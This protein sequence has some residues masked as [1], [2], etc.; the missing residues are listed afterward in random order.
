M[1][2]LRQFELLVERLFHAGEFRGPCFSGIGQ[3]AIAA[4]VMSHF[5]DQDWAAGSHRNLNLTL[6]VGLPPVPMLA[7]LL[8]KRTRPQTL[9]VARRFLGIHSV[10]GTAL[11]TA[12]GAA[13]SIKNKFCGSASA[14]PGVAISFCGEGALA[15]GISHETL[16]VAR[17]WSLPMLFVVENNGYAGA[18][19]LKETL[20]STVLDRARSF[21]I[22][23]ASVD[24]NDVRAVQRVSGDLLK[25]V[26]NE[27]TP[28][29]LEA[30][31]YRQRAHTLDDARVYRSREEESRWLQRDPI[32]VLSQ[33]MESEGT[34]PPGRLLQ[35]VRECDTR[36]S[37]WLEE[38]RALPERA[39]TSR[40]PQI[41][42]AS[43]PTFKQHRETIYTQAVYE[44]VAEAMNRD[45]RAVVVGT[46]LGSGGEPLEVEHLRQRFGRD[47]VIN[48]PT[49]PNALC[50]M[51]LGASITGARPIL[52]FPR[53]A[54][55][56]LCAGA[57]INAAQ[58]G[59]ASDEN[60][61]V[62]LVIR[63][64]YG[65]TSDQVRERPQSV[66]R[67]FSHMPGLTI[68]VPATPFDA[69]AMVLSAVDAGE[70]VLLLEPAALQDLRGPVPV[71]I[72][73]ENMSLTG[74]RIAASGDRLTCISY[75]R[76]LHATLAARQSLPHPDNVEVIDLRC[77]QPLD[78]A[79]IVASAAKTGALLIV[80]DESSAFGIGAEVLAAVI[81]A[82]VALR[83]GQRLIVCDESGA[84]SDTP[85][86][87]LIFGAPQ[88]FQMMQAMLA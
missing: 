77:I 78:R 2:L 51:L 88:I 64:T 27:G 4:G 36:L 52:M 12:A 65:P 18:S 73:A 7:A 59:F 56:A 30:C 1:V 75:G 80:E 42:I 86:A 57:L 6:C 66:E 60:V 63:A 44:G 85:E 19:P 25:L 79:T 21:S 71:E 55:L 16:N 47:R 68:A 23:A 24:G 49:V 5:G 53:C 10:T 14:V 32:T 17:L 38:A 72:S 87:A 48:A 41:S 9:D 58:I 26:R 33:S 46:D 83:Y 76:A 35:I 70:P 20:A 82:G 69:R 11:A 31:T 67:C 37:L 39:S 28:A 54:D 34:L 15:T 62:P 22:P 50:H 45:R 84:R 29:L 8:G 3:E 74:A 13:F 61:E 81:E 43:I 40:A